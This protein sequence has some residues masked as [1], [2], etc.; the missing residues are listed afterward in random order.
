MTYDEMNSFIL[1]YLKNDITGRAIMLT[2]EWG[3][4]KSYY[5]K[6]TL[7]PFLEDKDN[8][9]HKCVIVSLYGLSDTSEI[10]K[11]IYMELRTIKKSPSTETGSTAKVVGKIVSK[12][13]FNGLVSKI[14]FDIGN[15]NDDD[16][17]KVYESVDLEGKLIVFEDIERTQIDIIELLGY[18]NNMCENDG[19]KV[20]LVTNE[21]EL[22]TT[23]EKNEGEGKTTRYYTDDALA[24]KRAKEKTIG[25][26]IHF[27]CD[28]TSAIKEI[29]HRFKNESLSIFENDE[30]VEDIIEIMALNKCYNLRSFLIAC[31]KTSDI[32]SKISKDEMDFN[33]TIFYSIISFSLMM[34][35]GSFPEWNGTDLVS[36]DLGISKYPL[37]RF[38]Y[39]YIRWQEL[40]IDDIDDTL[41]AHKR[42]LLYDKHGSK[43]DTDLNTIY[44]Y[45]EHEENDV[46]DAL[47]RIEKRLDDPE[48]IP[49]YDYRKLAYFLIECNVVLGFDYSSC[50]TKMIKNITGKNSEIDE[51]LLFLPISD[52]ID[53][54][55][56]KMYHAF[57]DELKTALNKKTKNGCSY[58]PNKISG[59]HNQL[60]Q[61]KGS[62]VKNHKFL[63]EFDIDKI[64]EMIFRCSPAQLQEFRSIMFSVYRNANSYDFIEEDIIA[65]KSLKDK[66]KER[67]DEY[68]SRID[69]IVL[70]Q[71]HLIIENIDEFITKLSGNQ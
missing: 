10:S 67:I 71:Y 37:Y 19:V 17:Q 43:N 31:Q 5:V 4:G 66:V 15:I 14:G 9:K 53:E 55:E 12:T 46:I 33:K 21:S 34:K 24:Y 41:K 40:N 13:V 16:L 63:S 18:I 28:L 64:A 23:Y 45:L 39:N 36:P 42:M 20:L 32:L 50:K 8:D 60:I 7:K 57:I 30:C 68:G 47:T 22:L 38:C 62:I 26:T 51:E 1:N 35:N 2:G 11:A 58:N 52:F 27:Q 69:K 59:F 61:N 54:H 70:K 44:S 3:S 25:D 48:E 65:M 6:N 49:F 56:K 29:I